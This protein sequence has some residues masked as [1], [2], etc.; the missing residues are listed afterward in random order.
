MVCLAATAKINLIRLETSFHDMDNKK[1]VC[2]LLK[3]Y[4]FRTSNTS[5]FDEQKAYVLQS[6]VVGLIEEMMSPS[7]II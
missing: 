3:K 6:F 7:Q 5:H 2:S 4:A 1:Y